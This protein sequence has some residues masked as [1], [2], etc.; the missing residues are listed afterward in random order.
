[1]F[2]KE[3]INKIKREVRL[4]ESIHIKT[5]H[6]LGTTT[7]L[8]KLP[9][10]YSN[11]R[12]V[13][14]ILKELTRSNGSINELKRMVNYNQVIKIDD[15]EEMTKSVNKF[16]RHAMNNGLIVITAGTSNPLRLREFKLSELSREESVMIVKRITGSA[17]L[18]RILYEEVG[19]YPAR[20]VKAARLSKRI[21]YHTKEGINEIKSRIRM[22]KELVT[23]SSLL[24]TYYLLQSLRY[25]LYTNHLMTH[26]FRI[27]MIAYLI[28]V[29]IRVKKN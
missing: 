25:A 15:A 21:D 23:T 14:D 6:G 2:R 11:P 20:L 9:G 17:E 10:A 22:R 13:K 3:L 27:A 29:L 18:G 7:L 28:R 24:I 19:G 12:S 5:R 4:G 8:R 1:M 26:G 16:L